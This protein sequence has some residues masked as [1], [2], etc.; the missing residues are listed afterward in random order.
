MTEILN[1][2]NLNLYSADAWSEAGGAGHV[3]ACVPRVP[4]PRPGAARVT[5][6]CG[7]TAQDA[8]LVANHGGGNNSQVG[9]GDPRSEKMNL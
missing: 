2:Y 1:I 5:A 3:A 4:A 8:E 6:G 7:N 9:Q